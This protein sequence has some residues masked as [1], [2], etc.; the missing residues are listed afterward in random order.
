MPQ[1]VQTLPLELAE[2]WDQGEL[3]GKHLEDVLDYTKSHTQ[4]HAFLCTHTPAGA[5]FIYESLLS[6]TQQ[7]IILPLPFVHWH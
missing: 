5:M 7:D 2:T 1:S 4:E 6:I 3:R